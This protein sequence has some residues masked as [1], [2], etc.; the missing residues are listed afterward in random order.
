MADESAEAFPSARPGSVVRNGVV[1]GNSG[2]NTFVV[3]VLGGTVPDSPARS[4]APIESRSA[5]AVKRAAATSFRRPES[6][7]RPRSG[8][9]ASGGFTAYA[10]GRPNR[11]G[12]F[13][14][15]AADNRFRDEAPHDARPRA[16]AHDSEE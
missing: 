4:K 6:G 16:R 12:R 1:G 8:A 9:G 11:A 15:V 13:L 7:A 2:M 14:S 5:F 3:K 10:L